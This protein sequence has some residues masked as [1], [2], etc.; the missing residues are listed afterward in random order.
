MKKIV[1]ALTLMFALSAVFTSCREKKSAD[2]TVEEA[3]EDV[4]DEVED[5]VD[6]VTDDN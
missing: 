1:L 3:I 4:G 6:E 5:A 2:E